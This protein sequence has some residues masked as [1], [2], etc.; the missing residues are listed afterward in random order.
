M[1]RRTW[2]TVSLR[3]VAATVASLAAGDL[4]GSGWPLRGQ[5]SLLQGMWGGRQ[6]TK[7][8]MEQSPHLAG[9][10]VFGLVGRGN[11]NPFVKIL[12]YNINID[13]YF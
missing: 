10:V 11:L 12:I 6:F 9:F 8:Q 3:A 4:C 2:S 1:I 13:F 5:A 7:P